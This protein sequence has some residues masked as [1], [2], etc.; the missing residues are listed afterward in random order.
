DFYRMFAFFH[1]IPEKGRDGTIAPEPN[2]KVLTGGTQEQYERLKT[3]VARMNEA[4]RNS[5]DD[6]RPAF[7]EW[8][9][10]AGERL[11]NSSIPYR[12][13]TWHFPLD[14]ETGKSFTNYA[15]KG[16]KPAQ[17]AG[18]SRN[19]RIGQA[20][21][22]GNAIAFRGEEHLRLPSPFG[23]GGFQSDVPMTWSCYV[24]LQ[25]GAQGDLFASQTPSPKRAG[26]AISL[27]GTDDNPRSI[28]FR[29]DAD[30][31]QKDGIIVET[32][33]LLPVDGD[34]F[35]HVSLTYDGSRQASGVLIYLNGVAVERQVRQ[36]SLA[37]PVVHQEDH[38]LGRTLSNVV[39]DEVIL[40]RAVLSEPNLRLLAQSSTTDTLLRLPKRQPFQDAFLEKVYFQGKHPDYQALLAS[41]ESAVGALKR[42]ESTNVTQVS[43]MQEMPQPRETY[44]LSRGA[45]DQ[46][47]QSEVIQPAVFSA[48]PPLPKGGKA[49]RLA[50]ARWLFQDD[51]PLTARVAVNRFWQMLFGTG[52]VKTP[53]DFGTQ[54]ASPSHPELLD[55]LALT[56]Q[57]LGWDV[58][59]M[60]KVIV[61]SD[62]YAQDSRVT[63]EILEMDPV[64]AY[65]ARGPRYRL[66]AFVLRDQAL[67]ASGLL[68]NHVGG[69]PVMPYQPAGL[70]NELSAKG[71]KYVEAKDQGLYRRSLYTFWRRTVPPP[72]MMNFDAAAREV[73]SVNDSRT[74]TPLQALN[75]L[76]DPQF[77][78]AA[79]SLGERMMKEAQEETAEARIA[80]GCEVVLSRPP[81]PAESEVFQKGYEDYL[82]SFQLRPESTQSFLDVGH[83]SPDPDL[84]PAE[85][86]ACAAVASVLLNLDEA[87]TKE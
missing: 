70:W 35:F 12:Q 17:L 79:R 18:R 83:S 27:V 32:E 49:D 1:N 78:E 33:P 76:N 25:K 52:L 60:L 74:N 63:P 54:G 22:F 87:V 67:A 31:S 16:A 14:E 80:L 69:P 82:T 9:K 38:L 40:H 77:V 37:A 3:E 75:L 65:L 56:F 68:V 2:M 62:T 71:F 59:A 44:L 86:A 66:S 57:D 61:L 46:P 5:A 28:Q 81:S 55:W 43:I 6:L 47:D 51:H 20:G 24:K 48:L 72:S 53:E 15:A 84:P 36:D 85:L 29:L 7:L 30:R 73:C 10:K 21:R 58:K 13:R 41:V 19:A 64:N 34:E 8:K 39:V 11:S 50:L 45:Y 23:A 4:K 26:Y 42:F